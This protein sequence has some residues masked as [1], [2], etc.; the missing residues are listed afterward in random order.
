MSDFLTLL[1]QRA[2]LRKL[3]LVSMDL[4]DT[5][6]SHHITTYLKS[7]PNLRDLDLSWNKFTPPSLIKFL[8]Y[9][10]TINQVEHLNISWNS[11]HVQKRDG[12]L[13]QALGA[14][15]QYSSNL[16]HLDVSNMMLRG[17]AVMT[18]VKQMQ[19]SLTLMAVHLSGNIITT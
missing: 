11:L 17:N 18:I 6:L 12:E 14:L 9:L 5:H 1:I 19:K 4:T 3:A 15:V 13:K 16:M 8:V 2:P 10:R 7:N